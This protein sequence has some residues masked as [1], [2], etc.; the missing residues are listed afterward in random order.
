MNIKVMLT[1]EGT[2][3]F[4]DGGVSIW[5]DKMVNNLH[6]DFDFYVYS[7]MMNP[8]VT[9]KF[10]LPK[11]TKL[12]KV[13]LWGTEEPSEYINIPF[14]KVYLMKKQTH[15]SV[16]KE[17]FIP[18]FLEMVEEIVSR[19]KDPVRFG[20]VLKAMYLFFQ[21][22]DYKASFKSELVWDA[23]QNYIL[24]LSTQKD[25]SIPKPGAFSI[26][27][28]LSWLYR[29]MTILNTPYPKVDITHS[30]AAAFCGIPCVIE[31]LLHNTPFLLTEHGIYLRE[32]YLSLSQRGYPS[33][34]TAFLIRL[35]HSM[36][37]INYHYADQVSPVCAYNTRWEQRL[38]VESSRIRVI[39]NGVDTTF[40][41]P[42]VPD[43]NKRRTVVSVARIDPVK[44][45]QTLMKA[46]AIVKQQLPDVRFFVYGSITV[47][48]YYQEC[49]KL[50]DQLNL[51]DTFVFAG[52]SNDMASVYQQADIIALSSISE[53]FPFALIEA[54]MAGKAVIST[55]V[56][57]I[58]EVV[59][60]CGV[61]V[62]PRDPKRFAEEIIRLMENPDLRASLAAE[63]RDR[64]LNNFNTSTVNAHYSESYFNLAAASKNAPASARVSANELSADRRQ[65]KFLLEKGLRLKTEKQ[66]PDAILLFRQAMMCDSHSLAIPFILASIADCYQQLGNQ[67]AAAIELEKAD[68]LM[69]LQQLK[70]A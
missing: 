65:Q 53:G 54:M 37:S 67:D 61:L 70:M 48:E 38:G 30:S 12:I 22:Y 11:R 42:M 27:N 36:V 63:G 9:Q 25:H 62:P 47:Q 39:Y 44:D 2:Y 31:K 58:R 66:Y 24:Q 14:S 46:A 57:G 59:G 69:Q 33:F 18:L 43:K 15:N 10:N 4:H 20:Q 60:D 23:Y 17:K 50:K 49:L 13:P 35:I 3:P 40:W 64:A 6:S 28:S 45:T 56:G 8:F 51:G 1:T 5:C 68:V 19:K 16:I 26:I 21:Q 34:L 7:I 29:F 32:Q 55:D 52:H 41:K